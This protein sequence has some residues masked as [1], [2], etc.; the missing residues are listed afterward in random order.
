VGNY[1]LTAVAT[2]DAG[3]TT[4]SAAANITV[5]SGI[6][7]VYYIETDHLNTPRLIADQTG[8]TVWRNDN[9]EPFGDSVPNGDPN[10]IGITFDF[11]LRFPGQYFDNETNH[12]YN[13]FRY[14]DP[15]IGR[16][17]ESDPIG[18]RGGLNTYAY[19][20]G[21]PTSHSDPTGLAFYAGG[22]VTIP[23]GGAGYTVVICHDKCNK[24]RRFHYWKLCGGVVGPG[25]SIVGGVVSNMEGENCK[26][27][28]YSGWFLEFSIGVG[29]GVAGGDIGLTST[30][31]A[32]GTNEVGGGLGTPGGSIMMCFYTF[33]GEW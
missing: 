5:K 16:Y 14:L 1:S 27:D 21:N 8:N 31:G 32:S 12:H 11:P 20:N 30:G 18:L 29:G 17:G 9:T 3:E 24:L 2:N 15:G 6:A 26:P 10:N 19:V 22:T 25:A 33:I 4:T 13:Y 7:Q 28:Q 23:F